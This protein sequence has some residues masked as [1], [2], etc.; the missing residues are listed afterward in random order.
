M[1][2]LGAL[3]F[4]FDGTIA[5]SEPL[6]LAAFQRT[7]ADECGLELTEADYKAH[8]LAFDDQ[9]MMTAFLADRGMDVLPGRFEELLAIKEAHF[10]ALAGEPPILP[11]AIALIRAAS[12]RWPLAVASG[13]LESE[14]RPILEDAGLIDC[15]VTIVSAEMVER[16]KPDPESFLTALARI[17]EK[18]DKKILPSGALVFEDSIPGVSSGRAAG[19][20][21]LAI[22][23]SFPRE[24]LNQADRVVDSLEEIVDTEALASWFASLS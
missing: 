7:F 14:I 22:T 15:F 1:T 19:M 12:K 16:G 8:Y 5:D 18:R 24:Q 13:A 21:V 20:R 23:N 11:G 3:I 9:M 10:E 2:E 6:H 17:N 4:D